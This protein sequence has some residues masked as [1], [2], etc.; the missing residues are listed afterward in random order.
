M[1][2]FDHRASDLQLHLSF[3]YGQKQCSRNALQSLRVMG[4]GRGR[5]EK[6]RSLGIVDRFS[7]SPAKLFL[8]ST[9]LAINHSS[10]VYCEVGSICDGWA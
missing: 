10:D 6:Q 7:L 1:L 5:K 2:N 3:Y 9:I 8:P 4:M